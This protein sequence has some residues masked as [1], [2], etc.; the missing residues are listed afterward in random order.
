MQGV[1]FEYVMDL[2]ETIMKDYKD[3]ADS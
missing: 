2:A 3:L 1:G